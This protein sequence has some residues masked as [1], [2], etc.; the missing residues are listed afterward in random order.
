MDRKDGL[1]AG[2]PPPTREEIAVREAADAVFSGARA[3]LTKHGVCMNPSHQG[4]VAD[5]A[6]QAE[7]GQS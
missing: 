7:E 2:A 5:P 1:Q 3:L 6:V 4:I